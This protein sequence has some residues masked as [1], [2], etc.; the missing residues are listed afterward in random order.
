MS[1]VT[2]RV[3]GMSCGG[4]VRNVTGVLKGIAGVEEVEVDLER[5]E[6]RVRFDATQVSVDTLRQAIADAGF[7]APA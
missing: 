7:D 6:A 2:M 3:E 4:C 1:E 5:A